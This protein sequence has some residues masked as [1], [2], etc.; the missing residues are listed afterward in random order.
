V[1]RLSRRAADSLTFLAGGIAAFAALPFGAHETSTG[2]V[3]AAIAAVLLAVVLVALLLPWQRLRLPRPLGAVPL[4][5]AFAA[6]SLLRDAEGGPTSGYGPLVL[7]PVF[8]LA[9]HATRRDVLASLGLVAAVFV[10]PILAVPSRYP[11]AE[12]R[13]ALLWLIV[14]P[15]VGLTTQRLVERVRESARVDALTGLPN[16]RAWEERLPLAL[17][18]AVRSGRPLSIAM[19]DLDGFKAYNDAH[20]HPAGDRLLV[21]A[22]AA[23]RQ[24]VRA[25]DLLARLGGDEFA[26]LLPGAPLVAAEAV[27]AR[28]AAVTPHVRLSAGV[29]EWRRDESVDA[30][31]DRAD[32]ALYANKGVRRARR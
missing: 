21:D 32:A 5:A 30:L 29:V 23:W 1:P 15:V 27:V 4:L 31:V 17:E 22:A 12:W 14:T 25:V 19:L 24:Q 20:G 26:L 13:R 6:I 11:D 2:R 10:V 28:A 18:V 8:W 9:L 7:L 3:E 16:R